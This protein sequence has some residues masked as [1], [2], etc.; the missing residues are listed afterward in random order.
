MKFLI[1]FFSLLSVNTFAQLEIYGPYSP[2]TA[3]GINN[4]FNYIKTLDTF[5]N[6]PHEFQKDEI[7]SKDRMQENINFL[8]NS[9]SSSPAISIDFNRIDSNEMNTLFTDLE[10]YVFDNAY[11]YICEEMDYQYYGTQGNIEYEP[12]PGSSNFAFNNGG[13]ADS[14]VFVWGRLFGSQ[15]V[16]GWNGED[17]DGSGSGGG[18][19]G[20]SSITQYNGINGWT[21]YR[22][23]TILDSAGFGTV[24]YGIRR[25]RNNATCDTLNPIVET[26]LFCYPRNNSNP[27]S[28]SYTSLSTA[29]N[30]ICT[31]GNEDQI[32][33]TGIKYGILIDNPDIVNDWNQ[34]NNEYLSKDNTVNLIDFG[35][36][37]GLIT[38]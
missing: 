12:G 14:G 27:Y 13:I 20:T 26:R 38:D 4:N 19:L 25:E 32:K 3:S 31:G 11:D 24:Y 29:T 36:S 18:N 21:Y 17:I 33:T 15:N 16:L 23:P 7:I 34:N 9:I 2:I 22:G 28:S 10:N 30:S 8:T 5:G 37:K 1:F 35:V 6:L